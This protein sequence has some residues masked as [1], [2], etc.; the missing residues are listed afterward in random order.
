VH[1]IIV[2][3]GNLKYRNPVAPSCPRS[4]L[5]FPIAASRCR[6]IDVISNLP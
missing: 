4:A 6:R 1:Q 5:P 2:V 3:G